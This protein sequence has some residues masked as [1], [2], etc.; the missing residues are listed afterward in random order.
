M[1]APPTVKGVTQEIAHVKAE[2][3]EVEA[4]HVEEVENAPTAV[5]VPRIPYPPSTSEG[6][7]ANEGAPETG[8]VTGKEGAPTVKGVTS[9]EGVTQEGGAPEVEV[10]HV[11][12]VENALT[13]VD[14][15][16]HTVSPTRTLPR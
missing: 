5:D 6:A 8:G 7:T 13:A 10:H 16:P 15:P 9:K 4:H 3:G 12:A 14:V 2:A 11:E 1:R